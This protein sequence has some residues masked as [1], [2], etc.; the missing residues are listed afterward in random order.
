M[1]NRINDTVGRWV[2]RVLGVLFLIAGVAGLFLPILQGILFLIIGTLLLAGESI[3][4][5]R[6][7]A[8]LSRRY[9]DI[10][11][12]FRRWRKKYQRKKRR[13]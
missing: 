6:K 7:I 4:V 9:P 11:A 5:R 12:T 3:W 2:R 10:Y 13:R 1:A 8:G